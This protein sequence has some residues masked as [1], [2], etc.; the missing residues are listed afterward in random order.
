LLQFNTEDNIKILSWT[1]RCHPSIASH[2]LYY[3]GPQSTFHSS[4]LTYCGITNNMD[5]QTVGNTTLT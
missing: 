5:N 2:C 4:T 3:T 1:K